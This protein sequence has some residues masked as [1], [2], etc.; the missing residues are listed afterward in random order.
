MGVGGGASAPGLGRGEARQDLLDRG[1]LGLEVSLDLFGLLEHGR[2]VV[3]GG[4]GAGVGGGGLHVLTDDDD[5]QQDQLQEGLGD[6]GDDD[7]R[8][9]GLEG[10][11]GADQGEQREQVGAPHRPDDQGDLQP[12]LGVQ[13]SDRAGPVH[14]GDGRR[15]RGRSGLLALLYVRVL[16]VFEDAGHG[17]PPA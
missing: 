12:D 6:P 15:H 17:F 1:V 9:A 3:V 16:D 5:R 11:R 10:R 14:L 8:V 7:E 4:V 2:R 13:A